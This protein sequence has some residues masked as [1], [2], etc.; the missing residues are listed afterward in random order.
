MVKLHDKISDLRLLYVMT[1]GTNNILLYFR[2][3]P[4]LLKSAAL[5]AGPPG[6][7]C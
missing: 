1:Y 4:L 2:S 7:H 5:Y 3:T 6:A